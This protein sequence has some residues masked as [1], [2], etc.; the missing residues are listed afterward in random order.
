MNNFGQIKAMKVIIF[1]KCWKFYVY[2]GNAIKLRENV[3][4]VEDNCVWTC[5]GRFCQLWQ[6]YKWWAVKVLKSGPKILDTTKRHQL[7]L[8]YFD[9]NGTLE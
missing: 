9:S 8:N 6:E 7:K 2:F 5:C 3:D 1:S 4:G